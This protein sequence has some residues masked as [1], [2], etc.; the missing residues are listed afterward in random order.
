MHSPSPAP[1]NGGARGRRSFLSPPRQQWWELGSFL[2]LSFLAPVAQANPPKTPAKQSEPAPPKAQAKAQAK[3]Q[4]QAERQVL[5]NA[6]YDSPNFPERYRPYLTLL[7]KDE[8]EQERG[9][10]FNKIIRGDIRKQRIA[11]TFDDGPHPVYTLQLLD[12]LRRTHTPATFFVVGRQV[13]KNPALVQLEVAEGHEVG[14]HTY[15]HVNLTLIPPE[16]IPYELD[17]C[18]AAIKKATGSS[19]RF[20]RPPGGDYNGDVIRDAAKRGY[21]TTLW[22]NDPGDFQK[23][24]ADVIL[25]RALDHLENGAIILMHDGIPQTLQVLPQFI[26]EARRRGYQFVT[27]S[28]LA[29]D[30]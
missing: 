14:N 26:A 25:H 23:P 5:P 8:Y 11:L 29:R 2:A 4:V 18:D 24:P 30:Y 27:V 6:F 12:I 28:R 3:A 22:T 13:E 19:A 7:A 10:K 9:Y 20:F 16:L 15:D 17:Q 21:I 1:N